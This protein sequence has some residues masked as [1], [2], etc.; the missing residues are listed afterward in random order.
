MD[1]LA[2]KTKG[3]DAWFSAPP[4]AWRGL[5]TLRLKGVNVAE[6]DIAVLKKRNRWLKSLVVES[7]WTREEIE[8]GWASGD[9]RE[10]EVD[11]MR[12]TW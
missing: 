8:A 1:K 3:K 7:Y 6:E 10:R 12:P 5:E 2:E 11:V 9:P 4:L